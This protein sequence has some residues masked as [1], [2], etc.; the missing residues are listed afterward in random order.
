MSNRAQQTRDL[1]SEKISKLKIAHMDANEGKKLTT[2]GT[3]E[4]HQ[5]IRNANIARRKGCHNH[6]LLSMIF[7]VE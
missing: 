5:E 6:T 2:V 4:N 3:I 7:C 1:A